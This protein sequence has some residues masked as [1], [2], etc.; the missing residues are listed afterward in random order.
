MEPVHGLEHPAQIAADARHVVRPV[1]QLFPVKLPPRVPAR[2]DL[3][4]DFHVRLLPRLEQ[5]LRVVHLRDRLVHGDVE[6]LLDAHVLGDFIPDLDRDAVH[7]SA[8]ARVVAI[9]P[10]DDPHH[11]QRVEH[12]ADDVRYVRQ[13]P[14]PGLPVVRDRLEV[15]LQRRQ[16]LDVVLALQV[17]LV[18]LLELVL[19]PGEHARDHLVLRRRLDH[20]DH[21]PHRGEVQLLEQTGQRRA[22][23]AP[24]VDLRE[25]AAALRRLLRLAFDGG[26]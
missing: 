25:R 10:R 21:L 23:L 18:E 1:E 16:K 12:R 24:V 20:L 3:L 6:D 14:V 17:Q 8:H 5:P 26:A 22:A 15:P 11:P 7:Q 9:M 4:S 19:E 13:R 2:L